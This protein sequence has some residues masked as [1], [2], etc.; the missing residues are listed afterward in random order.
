MQL[1]SRPDAKAPSLYANAAVF[2]MFFGAA[3]AT[4]IGAMRWW[5]ALLWVG[6]LLLVLLLSRRPDGA[7]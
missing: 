2:V 5:T 4:E 1:K 6:F 3:L 7:P